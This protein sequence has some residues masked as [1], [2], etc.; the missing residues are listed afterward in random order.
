M[1]IKRV[2]ARKILNSRREETVEVRVE[3]DSGSFIASAPS[4]K[5]KGKHELNAFSSR[6]LQFSIDFVNALGRKISGAS[7]SKFSELE[8]VEA[9]IVKA[10][11]SVSK[12]KAYK[13]SLIGAN[14]LYAL[15]A[16]LLKAAA[17]SSGMELWQFLCSSPEILPLPLGNIIGGGLHSHEEKKTD[18]QEFLVLPRTKHFF[19]AYFINLQAYK[20][21]KQLL[22]A[23]GW[24]ERL[25]DENSLAST[26]DNI[27]VLKILNE[28]KTEIEEKFGVKL[29]L[30]VDVA[31]SSFFKGYYNYENYAVNKKARLNKQEQLDFILDLI[32]EYKLSYIE[33]P[34]HEEDFSGFSFL[35]KEIKRKNL[36][37]LL[38]SDDLT[39]TNLA[40]VEKAVENKCVNAVIVKPNQIGSLLGMKKVIDFC[41]EQEIVCVI[42]HRSGETSDDTLAHLAVGWQLP[43]IKT[44]VLG[45]E[46]FAKLHKLLSIERQIKQIK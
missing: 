35:L 18:F 33:D 32:K 28:I 2:E 21:A 45:R 8:D 42:S 4:G 46:R 29:E 22:L 9:L 25:T 43:I 38:A 6:G 11:A 1:I 39:C 13:F 7:F 3:S 14:A 12:G 15:E 37:C 27:S 31:A 20:I 40:R 10:E 16:A 34:L 30:G 24:R 23:T 36:K 17:G 5:S 44:G 41:K 26:L 19:D